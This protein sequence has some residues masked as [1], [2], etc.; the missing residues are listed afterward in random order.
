MLWEMKRDDQGYEVGANDYKATLCR[1][2]DGHEAIDRWRRL[3]KLAGLSGVGKLDPERAL[4]FAARFFRMEKLRQATVD[5]LPTRREFVK[6]ATDPDASPSTP[7]SLGRC[8]SSPGFVGAPSRDPGYLGPVGR[9]DW[10]PRM[11]APP[12]KLYRRDGYARAALS[13][14][15]VSTTRLGPTTFIPQV[16]GEFFEA[17][18]ASMLS[19]PLARDVGKRRSK[20]SKRWADNSIQRETT[21]FRPVTAPPLQPLG[22]E[23]EFVRVVTTATKE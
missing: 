4:P 12:P 22:N 17:R 9:E 2:D 13:P 19:S 23:S 21:R 16:H 1:D 5:A 20:Q 8:R 6:P 14:I 18:R 15:A 7:R 3:R 10:R 11:I